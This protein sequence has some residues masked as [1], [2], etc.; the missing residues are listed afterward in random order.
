MSDGSTGTTIAL[1]SFVSSGICSEV[2]AAGVSTMSSLGAR[3]RAQRECPRHA[4]LLFECGNA[5]DR[6]QVGGRSFN[7]RML[8]PCGS[9]SMSATRMPFQA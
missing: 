8:E 5:V 2:T 3:R 1:A 9:W 6:W 7:Q 4:Q